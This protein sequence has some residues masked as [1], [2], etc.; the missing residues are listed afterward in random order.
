MFETQSEI[1]LSYLG[2][3]KQNRKTSKMKKTIILILCLY[4][5]SFFYAQ[6]CLPEHITFETQGSIDSFAI[7]YPGCT[8]IEGAVSIGYG[9]TN[10]QGLSSVTYI[11]GDLR[12]Y[13][14]DNLES[15]RGLENLVEIGGELAIVNVHGI[16]NLSGFDNLI[17]IGGS[18]R[19]W[20]TELHSL[21]GLLSLKV[22]GGSFRF[23]YGEQNFLTYNIYSDEQVIPKLDTILGAV[24]V[25]EMPNAWSIGAL[26]GLN[27][28]GGIIIS[29]CPRFQFIDLHT[30]EFNGPLILNN[31]ENLKNIN[32]FENYTKTYITN[33]EIK[34]NPKLSSCIY[35]SICDFVTEEANSPIISDN[36]VECNSVAGVIAECTGEFPDCPEGGVVFRRS[37]E[38]QDFR[39]KY[40]NCTEINGSLIVYD[41]CI[42]EP[43][44]SG[45]SD[46]ITNIYGL[47]NIKRVNGDLE[48]DV[49][50]ASAFRYS[51]PNMPNLEYIQGNFRIAH[52]DTLKFLKK[53]THVGSLE[54]DDIDGVYSFDSLNVS[55]LG[56]LKLSD[57]GWDSNPFT[58]GLTEIRGDASIENTSLKNMSIL[59]SL[60]KIGGNLWILENDKLE[61][62]DGLE[63]LEEAKNIY[64]GDNPSLSDVFAF[65][66]LN[67]EKISR[68]NIYRNNILESCIAKGICDIISLNEAS[69]YID[70]NSFGCDSEIEVEEDCAN[71]L[72]E[73]NDGSIAEFDCDDND[74]SIYPDAIEIPDNGIDEDCDGKDLK[75]EG[76]NFKNNWYQVVP[77]P[78][79]GHV[80]INV[81]TPQ[82]YSMRVANSIG[83]PLIE[84][85]GLTVSTSFDISNFQD[86]VYFIFVTRSEGTSI[87]R[88]IKQ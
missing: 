87:I 17:K 83:E 74:P 41:Y 20:E 28:L 9:V 1:V 86:G 30:K 84:Q 18:L 79:S 51:Y 82:E 22:I 6:G 34:A 45:S 16:N 25:Q 15:F 70:N 29:S 62:L 50:N 4:T 23:L 36:G 72:D 43:W 61:S 76:V 53:V 14:N 48:I 47:S 5:T 35:E 40:P 39:E 67:A 63:N 44:Q 2:V 21:Y 7:N 27:Y 19:I 64:I 81:S 69:V 31:N 37:D 73:D 54:L 24:V 42:D 60:V 58:R 13:N 11:G 68:L 77:N 33:L 3:S 71:V 88:L 59:E 80:Y 55:T 46:C 32:A 12:F 10:M 75:V 57:I 56:Y 65:D 49:Q 38:M 78:T 52:L 85:D 66:N 26:S 8:E